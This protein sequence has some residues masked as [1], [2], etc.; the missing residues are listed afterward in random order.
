MAIGKNKRMSKGKK[1]GK[2]KI[3]DPFLKKEWYDLKAPTLFNVRNFGKTLVT[4]SQ[5]TKLAVD[6]LRGRVYEVNLADLNNDEDQGFRKIKLCCE[7][8][9]GRNCLTD[10]HGM[11]MTR[12]KICSLVRKCHSLI[13]AFVDVTTLDGYT[14]RMFCIAFTKRRP[15]QVKSTCYAQTSQIRA[16]RK[17]MMTIMSAEAS[18]CQLRDLVKKFIPESIGKDI[19][20]ACKGIFPLQNVFI[21]KVKMLK[22]PKFDLTKL[23][24]LHGEAEDVGRKVQAESGEAQNTLTAETKA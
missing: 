17:K 24:E 5:G 16:I 10:F 12:D 8:I 4:K 18:K 20:N 11:D 7:D 19:E 15:E 21:R 9:Q 14:L 6:G 22:K 1:G 13:E 2:K 23:M 3:G